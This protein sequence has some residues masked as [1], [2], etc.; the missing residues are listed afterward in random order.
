MFCSGQETVILE[1]ATGTPIGLYPKIP[2]QNGRENGGA[3]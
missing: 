2:W 3:N 1:K